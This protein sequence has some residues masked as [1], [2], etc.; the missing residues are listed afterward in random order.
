[1]TSSKLFPRS[2]DWYYL[3][4]K[5]IA[6]SE[7]FQERGQRATWRYSWKQVLGRWCQKPQEVCKSERS[8]LFIPATQEGPK[9][10]PL[11]RQG[12]KGLPPPDFCVLL[13]LQEELPAV[14]SLAGSYT[15]VGEDLLHLGSKPLVWLVCWKMMSNPAHLERLGGA[16]SYQLFPFAFDVIAL[17]GC[18][19][20]VFYC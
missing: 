15:R 13:D 2:P 9:K 12:M 18:S 5:W 10:S 20:S 7:H 17:E 19:A 1:M 8:Y 3:S 4:Y 6:V 11:K 14:T 16:P